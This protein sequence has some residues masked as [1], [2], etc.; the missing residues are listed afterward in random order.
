MRSP[1]GGAGARA[2]VALM[3]A[4]VILCADAT[5]NTIAQ[6]AVSSTLCAWV[7]APVAE[8]TGLCA[9]AVEYSGEGAL[10]ALA[11]GVYAKGPGV[12]VPLCADFDYTR[13]AWIEESANLV[14]P[15]TVFHGTTVRGETQPSHAVFRRHQRLRDQRLRD[16]RLL[17]GTARA[18][19]ARSS[20]L[21]LWA[22][23][24]DFANP[25]RKSL[26]AA[27]AQTLNRGIGNF[28]FF[29][30]CVG[31][32]LLRAT[33]PLLTL[34]L[35]I[36]LLSTGLLGL[37]PTTGATTVS[38][39]G[40]DP[41]PRSFAIARDCFDCACSWV[42]IVF[43]IIL[44]GYIVW[45]VAYGLTSRHI[46]YIIITSAALSASMYTLCN[47]P[48]PRSSL[49][50]GGRGGGSSP[51]KRR[52]INNGRGGSARD[53]HAIQRQAI[54]NYKWEEEYKEDMVAGALRDDF[55]GNHVQEPTEAELAEA[56]KTTT[57]Q[58]GAINLADTFADIADENIGSM[59]AP[60]TAAAAAATVAEPAAAAAATVAGPA[61][62]PMRRMPPGLL[63]G[64][65]SISGGR[66]GGRGGG[67]KRRQPRRRSTQPRGMPANC[68]VQDAGAN[69]N[70]CPLSALR[71]FRD[72]GFN[73]AHMVLR[74]HVKGWLKQQDPLELHA[75]I[76]AD[77]K[78]GFKKEDRAKSDKQTVL[79]YINRIGTNGQWFGNPELEAMAHVFNRPVIV[80]QDE[81]DPCPVSGPPG[82]ENEEPVR[83]WY[84]GRDHYRAVVRTDLPAAE[85]K[86]GDKRAS[87]IQLDD[88]QPVKFVANSDSDMSTCTCCGKTWDGNAQCSCMCEG[89]K[90]CDAEFLSKIKDHY[91]VLGLARNASA[92]QIKHSYYKLALTHHPDKGGVEANF[93]RLQHAYEVLSDPTKRDLYDRGE[94]DEDEYASGSEVEAFD[95]IFEPATREELD[96]TVYEQNGDDAYEP[97]SDSV[98]SMS[99]TSTDSEAEAAK[100]AAIEAEITAQSSGATGTRQGTALRG[101]D[102]PAAEEDE[103]LNLLAD[104]A[105]AANA[106][107][108]AADMAAENMATV[109]QEEADWESAAALA[110]EEAE[111][112]DDQTTAGPNDRSPS[113]DADSGGD[114]DGDDSGVDA[115]DEAD[116][117][118]VKKSSYEL[119]VVRVVLFAKANG[120]VRFKSRKDSSVYLAKEA[121]DF[122]HDKCRYYEPLADEDGVPVTLEDWLNSIMAEDQNLQ[123]LMDKYSGLF[124]DV[125]SGLQKKRLMDWDF[126]R[127]SRSIVSFANGYLDF[128]GRSDRGLPR[129]RWV[130]NDGS[131][132]PK[133]AA[134]HLPVA[135]DPDWLTLSYEELLERCP[136]FAKVLQ[137]QQ[138]L[139]TCTGDLTFADRASSKPY[140]GTQMLVACLGRLL[141]AGPHNDGMRFMLWLMGPSGTGKTDV[142][143]GL[144]LTLVG[145]DQ[146]Q[147]TMDGKYG[148]KFV[149]NNDAMSVSVLA[150]QDVRG[151]PLTLEQLLKV[152]NKEKVATRG[153]RQQAS[154]ITPLCN[155]IA[156]S[157]TR[158]NWEDP[159]GALTGRIFEVALEQPP[160][161]DSS[162]PERMQSEMHYILLLS[163]RGYYD[164]S[165]HVKTTPFKSWQHPLLSASRRDQEAGH[166][167]AEMLM[168]GEATVELGGMLYTVKPETGATVSLDRL[169]ELLYAYCDANN[170]QR[171]PLTGRANHATVRAM[172]KRLSVLLELA[173]ERCQTHSLKLVSNRHVYKC[174]QCGQD[175]NGPDDPRPLPGG[176][177]STHCEE[178]CLTECPVG[179]NAPDSQFRDAYKSKLLRT[180][181]SVNPYVKNLRV[182]DEGQKEGFFGVPNGGRGGGKQKKA[183]GKAKKV[184]KAQSRWEGDP[185]TPWSQAWAAVQ[186]RVDTDNPLVPG[187]DDVPH[188]PVTCAC[189]DATVRINGV[190][191]PIDGMCNP[192]KWNR[193]CGGC[194]VSHPSSMT[195]RTRAGTTSFT[196]QP[197][198][199]FLDPKKTFFPTAQAKREWLSLF[200]GDCFDNGEDKDAWV[201]E[202]VSGR[203]DSVWVS[204]LPGQSSDVG[205]MCPVEHGGSQ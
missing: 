46:V 134:V 30:D 121:C 64:L 123:A 161:L 93:Q 88:E 41:K 45:P 201:A 113:N 155:L 39:G 24:P 144:I 177:T 115:D 205:S 198:E 186:W 138:Q 23:W 22:A 152:I 105:N 18:D 42:P 170:R 99:V 29:T 87:P 4:C 114:S 65:S 199:E 95:V 10:Y 36:L 94:L 98:S 31:R 158:P 162:V 47:R 110:A 62:A 28:L 70:C 97:D 102:D 82:T 100:V 142:F 136:V 1:Q 139:D 81:V 159:H 84:N 137:D 125:V 13:A 96:G 169:Q 133:V 7:P 20:D 172:L 90:E 57:P 111:K 164:L 190:G 145:R 112:A 69:G 150:L 51:P 17:D 146:V 74:G 122:G 77:G 148:D 8:Y 25:Y 147:V 157:N 54:E 43:W 181:V 196:G 117:V 83:L 3:L 203:F 179:C 175:V 188:F 163:L 61:A 165:K 194:P 53:P 60:E 189:D 50:S 35:P 15:A 154:D 59:S 12:Y 195:T 68:E 192:C 86:P 21:R 9:E 66:G 101:E 5:P 118:V 56:Q 187:R 79:N 108:V 16:Q 191:C 130:P 178:G 156:T 167:L 202:T 76:T 127:V 204:T 73:M 171:T 48:Q 33:G 132:A 52:R 143:F 89:C 72:C 63:K 85:E 92:A 160:Q 104:S 19:E 27:S 103:L 141:H 78:D 71:S 200:G 185:N 180:T 197:T 168:D 75:V 80:Y 14:N 174:K 91:E 153:M 34:C 106:G 120:I 37:A 119:A 26:K 55:S 182:V 32:L 44:L 58:T 6:S 124:H 131:E 116:D 67:P 49:P 128:S 183:K 109:R 140:S 38:R 149:V 40:S 151:Q 166:P 107:D 126:K 184:K 129:H 173:D 2:V 11:E 135:F 176:V 193:N